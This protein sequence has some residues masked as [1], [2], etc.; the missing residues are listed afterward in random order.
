MPPVELDMVLANV[1]DG[2]T[3]TDL[4]G[5]EQYV[6]KDGSL[7]LEDLSHGQTLF[8]RAD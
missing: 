4:L 2:R 8:L 1:A 3:L 7:W 6:V 5:G